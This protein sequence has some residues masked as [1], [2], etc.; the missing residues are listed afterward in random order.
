MKISNILCFVPFFLTIISCD[1][2]DK[3]SVLDDYNVV[4]Q[5]QSKNSSESMPLVGGDIG[6][7]VWVENDEVLVYIQRSGSL[8]ENGEYLKMGRIRL[9]LSPNPFTGASLF[10]QELKLQDGYIE[11]ESG[12][13][14]NGNIK[15]CLWIDVYNP[16]LHLEVEA[17]KSIE[18]TALYENWRTKD[19]E[20]LPLNGNRRERFTC[21]SL[22]G[23]P[24]KV[25]RV[26]DEID[27]S[28]EGVLFYHR[29]PENK[30]NPDF[31]IEQQGLEEYADQI[32]DDLKDRTFGG[33]LS[34]EG[35]IPAGTGEGTYQNTPYK[36][37]SI[38]SGEAKKRH[39]ISLV[40]HIEQAGTIEN[41][42]EKLL[43]TV[44][45]TT[46]D[47]E[48]GFINTIEWWHQF[49]NRSHIFIHPDSADPG[50]TVWQM[51][52]NYQLFRYQLGGNVKGEYPT[53]FNGGNLIYDPIL[54]GADKSYDPDWRQWGGSVHTAQNERLLYW[55][56]LKAGDFDAILPQFEL[57]R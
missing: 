53:K 48:K 3:K 42:K 13:G 45:E 47:H 28:G 22:E 30:L 51:S 46:A 52:R 17:N 50:N 21:F 27:F 24:G 20:L 8:S 19:R 5:T 57:Y 39:H 11:I 10:R 35:F 18:V 15:L 14:N 34:G 32:F 1:S 49:W 44:A 36:S 55:P 54:I 56:M 40:T 37:W 23:Y 16:V 41:W 12:G 2:G 29:N 25:F 6:C 4:W 31:F 33:M 7:N 43:A 26:K 9:Q 38:K